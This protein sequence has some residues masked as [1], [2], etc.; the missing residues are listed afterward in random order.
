MDDFGM[1]TERNDLLR[2][3]C[4][5]LTSYFFDGRVDTRICYEKRVYI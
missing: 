3:A 1:K 5:I 2:L 4:D